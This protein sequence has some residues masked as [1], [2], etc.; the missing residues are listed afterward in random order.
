MV[1]ARNE[2]TRVSL[3]RLVG[4]AVVICKRGDIFRQSLCYSYVHPCPLEKISVNKQTRYPIIIATQPIWC[5]VS[6]H[7]FQHWQSLHP[8][9][10][11][12]CSYD[13]TIVRTED[14]WIVNDCNRLRVRWT[15]ELISCARRWFLNVCIDRKAVH[16]L[17]TT[18]WHERLSR[19]VFSPPC[20]S[21][22]YGAR[23]LGCCTTYIFNHQPTSCRVP[24]FESK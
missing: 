24:A 8:N 4:R 15:E 7:L 18:F 10:C 22:R 17:D 20:S 2:T 3:E 21:P 16:R 5:I 9:R 19:R 11:D 1:S 12:V 23:Y 13:Q 14:A 6:Q